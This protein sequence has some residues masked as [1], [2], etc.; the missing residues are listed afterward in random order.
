MENNKNPKSGAK[1]LLSILIFIIFISLL[2]WIT[3]GIYEG[4]IESLTYLIIG[5]L[6][7]FPWIIPFVGIPLGNLIEQLNDDNIIKYQT[8]DRGEEVLINT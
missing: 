4:I 6:N 5:I 2:A 7:F 1:S 3:Y 8:T